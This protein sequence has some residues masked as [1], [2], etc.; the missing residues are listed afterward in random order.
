[1][2][3]YGRHAWLC[4]EEPGVIC[5]TVVKRGDYAH[6]ALIAVNFEVIERASRP[7]C[8]GSVDV[9]ALQPLSGP[10]DYLQ[11]SNGRSEHTRGS[12]LQSKTWP[13]HL[14]RTD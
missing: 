7:D 10:V 1:M 12:R 11:P 8:G 13:R 3:G 9:T 5:R 14:G 6:H 2:R 4:R